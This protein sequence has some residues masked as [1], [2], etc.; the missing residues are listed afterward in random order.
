MPYPGIASCLQELGIPPGA[1]QAVP[2]TLPAIVHS[3]INPPN[4]STHHALNDSMPILNHLENAFP[5]SEGY[6]TLLPKGT[7][8]RQVAQEVHDRL[9]ELKGIKPVIIRPIADKLDP[10][11][12]AYFRRTRKAWLGKS[13][14]ELSVETVKEREEMVEDLGALVPRSLQEYRQEG[15]SG[16]ASTNAPWIEG[17]REPTYADLTLVGFMIW[18]K[19][20]DQE[21]Y[22]AV[23]QKEWAA[24]L[25]E[26]LDRCSPWLPEPA[27]AQS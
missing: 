11:S 7:R 17:G 27:L 12:S 14:E 2:Y 8:S 3:S 5:E 20:A 18:L 4:G 16:S 9:R 13:L 6:P 22:H 21:C 25:R 26:M 15:E 10:A 19:V 1:S 24:P 23:V